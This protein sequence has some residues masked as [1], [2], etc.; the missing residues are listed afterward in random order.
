MGGES[1]TNGTSTRQVVI[2]SDCHAGASVMGYR[3]YLEQEWHEEFD[4]WAQDFADPWD[5]EGD[6]RIR[7]GVASGSSSWS[8]DGDTRT[9]LLDQDGITAE[10]LFPNTAPPFFPSGVLTA[11]VPVDRDDYR[12]RFAG[13]RAHNRWLAD[14]CNALPGRRAGIAQIFL[15][16]VD[17]AVAE[18]RAAADLGLKGILLPGDA[19]VTV[20]LYYPRYEP[21][22]QVC[23][24]LGLPVHRHG[25]LPADAASAETGPAGPAVGAMESGFFGRRGLAHLIFAGVFERHPDLVMVLTE[26]GS[27]WVPQYLAELDALWGGAQMKGS[28]LNY[29]AGEAAQYLPAP[30]SEYFARQC[31][32]GSSL[33]TGAEGA[34]R[35]EIGVGKIMWGSD[36]PHMEGSYPYSKEAIQA[37]FAGAPAD[38]ARQMLAGTAAAV[39]G[40]DLDALQLVA[41]RIGSPLAELLTEPPSWPR[42]PEDTVTPAL[43]TQNVY[44]QQD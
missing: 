11:S 3:D 21:V 32:L 37:A 36:F 20:P 35:E 10:V 1:G 42:F 41:D 12:R 31:Y 38:D 28:I 43:S 17:D 22:W 16:D 9:R 24:E 18:I 7:M 29:F 39:Y 25:N 26:V 23:E 5:D 13:L 27:G 44:L 14:F 33:F 6:D 40:F 34:M 30:P 8:W 4:A 15:N 19:L 2:S